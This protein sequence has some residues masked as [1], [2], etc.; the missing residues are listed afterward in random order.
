MLDINV[1]R[2][3]SDRVKAAV[4]RKKFPVDIDELLNVDEQ[5]RQLAGQVDGLRAKRKEISGSIPRL[6]GEAKAEAIA[7]G[8]ALREDIAKLEE[9]QRHNESRFDE[10]MMLV[11]GLPVDGIPDGASDEDNLEVRRVGELPSFDFEAKDHV[12]LCE[13]LGLADFT[14]AAKFAG[15]RAYLLTGHGALLEYAVTRFAMDLLMQR[16]WSPMVVPLLVNEKAMFGTGFFPHGLED[17]YQLP[18]DDLY[19]V[20]TSEVSL[21]SIHR[22]EVLGSEALPVRYAG[23]TTCFRR[24]AGNYGRDTRG[25]Y[26]VHQFQKVEQVSIIEASEEASEAEHYRLLDNSE[27]ILKALGIPYRVALACTQELGM[28]Q[29]RKHEIES[30]MPSRQAYCETHSCSTMH[31]FQARRSNLRY[32]PEAQAKPLF[33]HTLNNTAIASPRFLIPLLELNQQADGSVVIPEP[34][35]PYMNGTE[36][37]EPK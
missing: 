15:G 29:A 3:D 12:E 28:G 33:A 24:E 23:M 25:L 30:W 9:T 26:R 7:Q 18:N 35:R 8:R 5:R 22:D 13:T 19:L 2:R 21:V 6:D 36:V 1:I 11:P 27:S 14:R 10:L 4:A 37:L 17:T 16:G 34:L 20:G 31:D 32:R